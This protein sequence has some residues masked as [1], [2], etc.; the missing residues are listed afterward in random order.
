MSAHRARSLVVSSLAALLPGLLAAGACSEPGGHQAPESDPSKP[1]SRQWLDIKARIRRTFPR[2]EEIR[3]EDLARLL[4]QQAET[5]HA[6]GASRLILLDARPEQEFAVS[7]IRGARRFE[8]SLLSQLP[9]DGEIVVYCSV[10]YR[11]AKLAQRL[12]SRGFTRVRNLEGSL[13]EWANEGRPVYSAT[14]PVHKVHPYDA[15][16]GRLLDPSYR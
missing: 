5:G 4:S 12:T 1:D 9:K 16:W 14:G 8:E 13:F 6:S 3:T 7:H 15:K 10:G 11:S 2:V